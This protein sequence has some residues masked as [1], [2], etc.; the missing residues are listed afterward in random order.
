MVQLFFPISFQPAFELNDPTECAIA[1]NSGNDT[2]LP[3][4]RHDIVEVNKYLQDG[5]VDNKID[6]WFEGPLPN[7]TLSQLG[8]FGGRDHQKSL[9][10]ALN[11]SRLALQQGRSALSNV[12]GTSYFH[13]S[14]Y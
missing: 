4:L 10:E 11:K 14:S 9:K 3:P 2:P 1:N 8:A 6:R 13:M 5:L 12:R 7:I